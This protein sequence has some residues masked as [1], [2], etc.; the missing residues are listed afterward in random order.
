M[1]KAAKHKHRCGHPKASTIDMFQQMML[2]I[3]GITIPKGGCGFVWEHGNN[4]M[5]SKAAHKCPNCGKGGWWFRYSGKIK[6]GN[7]LV[8]KAARKR[9][10]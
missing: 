4:K 7:G 5:D 2:E 10:A 1:A 3:E 6:A 8:K 9:K